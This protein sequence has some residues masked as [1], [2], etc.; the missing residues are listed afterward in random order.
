MKPTVEQFKTFVESQE[1]L[2]IKW[3]GE[4]RGRWGY[5]GYAVTGDNG[6]L[7]ALVERMA[8]ERFSDK[9]GWWDHQ[10]TFGYGVIVLWSDHY[11]D[12]A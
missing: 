1:D 12:I 9:M 3:Y 7:G 10:D 6:H 5:K 11:F 8:V 4:Y 2:D